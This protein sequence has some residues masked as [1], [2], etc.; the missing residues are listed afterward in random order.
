MNKKLQDAY[1]LFLQKTSFPKGSHDDVIHDLHAEL[2]L[3]SSHMAGLISSYASGDETVRHLIVYDQSLENRLNQ[4]VS[5]K[6]EL[7]DEAQRF[8]DYLKEIK[9]L[10]D[11]ADE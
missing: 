10:V 4:R 7:K 6:P 8:F 5:E 2:A 9:K 1:D 11:L 3:Y